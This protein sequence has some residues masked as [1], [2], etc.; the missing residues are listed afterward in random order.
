M[1]DSL[2]MLLALNGILINT[3]FPIS[4]VN[5]NAYNIANIITT[6]EMNTLTFFFTQSPYSKLLKE[7]LKIFF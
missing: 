6:N 7:S 5:K 1:L 4:P 2:T 3:G